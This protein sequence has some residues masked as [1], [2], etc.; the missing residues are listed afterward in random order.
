MHPSLGINA[1][2]SLL[3]RFQCWERDFIPVQDA[4]C[5]SLEMPP[6]HDSNGEDAPWKVKRP[7]RLKKDG[8]PYKP[9]R[10]WGP[11]GSVPKERAVAFH[12]QLDVQSLQQ[13]VNNLSALRDILH[14]KSLL[15][16]HSPEGSLCKYNDQL[17]FMH[18][19]M[20][21]KV[22]LGHGIYG[23]DIMMDQMVRYSTFLR[24]I[25]MSGK[26]DSN[27]VAENSVV[28]ACKGTLQFQVLRSTIDM[29]FPHIARN[30]WLVSQYV[31]KLVEVP[32]RSVFHLNGNGK[33]T[34]YDVDMDF[35]SAFMTV[36]KDPHIVSLLLGRALITDCGLIGLV[37]GACEL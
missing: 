37:D 10:G 15:Q 26:V 29:I 22:D 35:V 32:G 34:K 4:S 2:T 23:P 12:L 24:F 19:V 8:R 6:K 17:A 31:G 25:C 11:Y 27:A 13:Q 1:A 3:P 33:C 30:E 36:V 16:R 20:D 9:R 14:T 28:I 5:P 21:E 18:S 7:Q